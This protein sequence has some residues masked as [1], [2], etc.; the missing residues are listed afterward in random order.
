VVVL[1]TGGAVTMP[2][3][4]D[5]AAVLQAWYPGQECGNSIADVLFGA[6]NPSGKLPQTYPRQ[7][8]HNPAVL[9][10]PGERGVA[11][12]GEGIF[13]GYRHY[14]KTQ[15]EP[16]F[17]FG[18]GLSY[19]NFTYGAVSLS[20]REI[21]PGDELI[22]TVDICNGGGRDGAEIVQLYVRDVESALMRPV[23]E[24]KGF[25]RVTLAAGETGTARFEL[26]MRSLAYFDDARDAW[27]ADAGTFET[28][29]G[30]SS[31]DIRAT[32]TLEL[33][34]EWVESVKDAWRSVHV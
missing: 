15:V 2:W 28:L 16:L 5:V 4:D 3:L 26:D 6:V 8:S 12:Y 18:H 32:A 17:P 27:V 34:G 20:R 33:T 24:L 1:Q 23:K 30:A 19:T 25:S 31:T 21:A 14:D 11:R 22:V 7:L 9:T 10:Y 13:A 29:I